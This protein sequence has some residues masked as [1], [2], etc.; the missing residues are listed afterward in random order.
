MREYAKNQDPRKAKV[1]YHSTHG[2]VGDDWY[3]C[4]ITFQDLYDD[5]TGL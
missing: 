3:Q 2:L 5:S 4:E 1:L